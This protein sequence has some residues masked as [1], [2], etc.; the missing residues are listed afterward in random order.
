MD[1]H[2]MGRPSCKLH[3]CTVPLVTNRHQ[4]CQYHSKY[5]KQCVVTDCPAD[6]EKGHH[7]CPLPSHREIEEQ[8]NAKGQAFF[9][10]AQHLKCLNIG[11]VLNSFMGDTGVELD[12]DDEDEV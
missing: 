6:T 2:Y 7:T 12:N 1:G 3:N 10:L 5:S 9:K 4:F 8:R 11:Q